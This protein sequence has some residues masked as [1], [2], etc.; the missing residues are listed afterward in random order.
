MIAPRHTLSTSSLLWGCA[1]LAAA[2]L[3]PQPAW[4]RL[5]KCDAGHG[6]VFYTNDMR[7]T[8]GKRCELLTLPEAQ[9]G[10]SRRAG[11]TTPTTS[12]PVGEPAQLVPRDDLRRRILRTELENEQKQIATL[13]TELATAPADAQATL[14]QRLERHRRNLEAITRELD[15]LR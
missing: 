2:L 6:E 11:N 12:R 7:V 10:P 4:A 8:R 13:E 5:W 14:R 15:R 3:A 1:A 9:P